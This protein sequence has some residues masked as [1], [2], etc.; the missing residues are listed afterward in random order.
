MV[1]LAIAVSNGDTHD[2]GIA[3]NPFPTD[4]C[5]DCGMNVGRDG[6]AVNRVS[7][8]SI[9]ELIDP[10]TPTFHD[11]WGADRLIERYGPDIENA[12]MSGEVDSG[13]LC[14]LCD[15]ETYVESQPEG[16]VE[17]EGELPHKFGRVRGGPGREYYNSEED[18]DRYYEGRSQMH[19]AR[20]AAHLAGQ[21]AIDEF[22]LRLEQWPHLSEPW[23]H[24]GTEGEYAGMESEAILPV[25]NDFGPMTSKIQGMFGLGGNEHEDFRASSDQVFEDAWDVVKERP[26]N[27]NKPS[28]LGGG[29]MEGRMGVPEEE[30]DVGLNLEPQGT[31][32]SCCESFVAE[33]GKIVDGTPYDP[34]NGWLTDPSTLTHTKLPTEQMENMYDKEPG[35]WYTA[36][37]DNDNVMNESSWLD[38]DCDQVVQYLQT[39]ILDDLQQIMNPEG[40]YGS[41]SDIAKPI[42]DDLIAAIENYEACERGEFIPGANDLPFG[43]GGGLDDDI[44][45]ASGDS[46]EDAWK[47]VKE[48]EYTPRHG[49]NCP[50]S[51]LPCDY[52]TLHPKS[53]EKCKLW[54]GGGWIPLED[55]FDKEQIPLHYLAQP[56]T[57]KESAMRHLYQVTMDNEYGEPGS[58][59]G[60]YA[61]HW[62]DEAQD[63]LHKHPLFIRGL[64]QKRQD[65]LWNNPEFNP[66]TLLEE[67]GWEMVDNWNTKSPMMHNWKNYPAGDSQ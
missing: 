29:V 61:Y 12:I 48:E 47:V 64:M 1:N 42:H 65:E 17:S 41:L 55:E 53:P 6:F 27:P 33:V 59:W 63:A 57:D 38:Q 23:T 7:G 62:D 34:M 25:G 36:H 52:H 22:N 11:L 32:G 60:R 21:S 51:P 20:I 43:M 26:E 10:H 24:P 30:P 56:I 39:V 44:M 58:T 45:I 49:I 18:W 35:S 3:P 40:G 8:D 31:M 4:V 37:N 19:D 50:F 2:F 66:W 46:F 28:Y 67:M 5:R 9:P 54:A 16:P 14:A 15:A 13:W